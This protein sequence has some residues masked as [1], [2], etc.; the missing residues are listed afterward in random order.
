MLQLQV[1]VGDKLMRNKDMMNADACGI[2]NGLMNIKMITILSAM[3]DC[4]QVC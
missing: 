4:R 3:L 2:L 1:Q